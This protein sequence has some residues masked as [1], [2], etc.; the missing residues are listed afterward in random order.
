MPEYPRPQMVRPEWPNLNGLWHSAGK[1]ATPRR[2]ARTFHA[3][4][5]VPFPVESA[6]S[7]VMKRPDRLWYRR[8]FQVPEK[9]AASGFAALRGG[10]LGGHRVGQ[11]QG[12]GH[13]SRRI[14]PLHVRHH[15]RLKP[16]GRAGTDR[17]R[18]RSDRR[19]HQPRGKQVNKPGRHLYTPTTG[20]WQTVWLEPVPAAQ[21]GRLMITPDV[22][23]GMS[24]MTVESVGTT[25]RLHRRGGCAR[26][27]SEW[28]R[29]AR[30][31]GAEIKLAIP[32]KSSS[33]RPSSRSCTT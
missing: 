17:P 23:A 4:I 15:R 5:L 30:R 26:R 31:V 11:R 27:A 33:G 28:R 12:A 32:R 13:A 16:T 21:I 14:R 9:W 8:T 29:A 24:A 25:R 20:I 7:G 22:D 6:L 3:Q 18:L 19:R 10:R 1:V 2:S